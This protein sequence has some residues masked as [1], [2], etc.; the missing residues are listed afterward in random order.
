M[1]GEAGSL[2]WLIALLVA[3]AL[4][5]A[6]GS[7]VAG[8][9]AA[10]APSPTPQTV[11]V[12]AATLSRTL[13]SLATAEW[14][15][16]G[17]LYAPTSGIIT[18]AAASPG[19]L[20]AGDVLIRVDERPIVVLPGE[21]ARLPAPRAG[22]PGPGRGVAPAVPPR[23]RLRRRRRPRAVHERHCGGRPRV[24]AVVG[25]P[26]T[27][28]VALGDVLFVP[29]SVLGAPARWVGEVAVG[30]PVAAGAPIVEVPADQPVLTI[31]FG[32]TAPAEFVPGLRGEAA[33][34]NGGRRG[35]V[36]AAIET[37]GGRVTGRVGPA[38]GLLCRVDDCLDL[39]PVEGA[40]GVPVDWIIVPP[41]SGPVVPV[42]A[43]QSDAGGG[44]F[45]LLP[46]GSRRPV[47]VR[48]VSGGRA[49]V[50]GVEAGETILLP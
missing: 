10:T 27:G 6:S 34:A 12:R 33:F 14:P 49:V 35:V 17:R 40:T 45:V 20:Q 32:S 37:T 28:I 21:T 44:A 25:L 16:V 42:A 19:V 13:R 23:G 7:Y 4:G 38:D 18:E 47:T 22:R 24:A 1:R 43:L 2:A 26:P 50:D 15:A 8:R 5:A 31:D 48:V 29:P 41:T 36:L 46:D 11:V 30:A 9:P 39:V 3:F